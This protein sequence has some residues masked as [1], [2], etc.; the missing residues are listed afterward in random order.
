[1]EQF[2]GQHPAIKDAFP[3]ETIDTLVAQPRKYLSGAYIPPI[4]QFVAFTYAENP[5]GFDANQIAT[6]PS[7]SAA[8]TPRTVETSANGPTTESGII[9]ICC[10]SFVAEKITGSYPLSPDYGVA[11]ITAYEEFTVPGPPFSPQCMPWT[12]LFMVRVWHN[13][14]AKLTYLYGN[15]LTAAPN[16]NFPATLSVTVTDSVG[17]TRATDGL[18]VIFDIT[19]GGATFD[20]SGVTT[21]YCQ[22]QNGTRAIVLSQQGVAIAPPIKAGAAVGPVTVY[23]SSRFSRDFVLYEL[24]V[25]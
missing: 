5:Y 19:G 16:R 25:T 24:N 1:M 8:V 6:I 17:S 11:Y 10:D 14:T 18:Q 23:A 13:M 7:A 12:A 4:P 22:I 20:P 21:R 15:K 2:T 3:G 9:P